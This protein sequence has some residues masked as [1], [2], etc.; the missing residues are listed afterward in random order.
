MTREQ[1][2]KE[3]RE[4]AIAANPDIQG[5]PRGHGM[6]R[7]D[8]NFDRDIRLADVL[9]AVESGHCNEDNATLDGWR[10]TLHHIVANWN[11]RE[12]R[13]DAQS[14]QTITFLHSLLSA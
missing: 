8:E 1:K 13:L 5:K 11:L 7:K 6:L 10:K 3:I 2:E 9:L 14:D 12:D 4:A